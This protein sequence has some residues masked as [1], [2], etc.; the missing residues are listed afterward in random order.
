VELLFF[1]GTFGGS[2][3]GIETRKIRQISLLQEP[4]E[5]L[6]LRSGFLPRSQRASFRPANHCLKVE[7]I[8][9]DRETHHPRRNCCHEEDEDD[10]EGPQSHSSTDPKTQGASSTFLSVALR[11]LVSVYFH[12]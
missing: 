4:R 2:S 11:R 3:K 7:N 1:I 10:E 6:D 12:S 9:V 8:S 5:D